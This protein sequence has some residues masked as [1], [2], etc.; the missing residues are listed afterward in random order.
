MQRRSGLFAVALLSAVVLGACSS[1]SATAP[2]TTASTASTASTTSTTAGT[3][4]TGGGPATSSSVAPP[5]SSTSTTSGSAVAGG[6][7][8]TRLAASVVGQQGAAGTQ[9]ATVVLRNTSTTPCG[10][11]GYPGL[12]LVSASGA[13]L[14]TVVVR[15]GTYSFTAMAPAATT[16]QPGKAVYFNMGYSD[17]P[18]GNETTCPTSAAME[19]TPPNAYGH[20][21]VTLHIAPCNGG[22]IA[23]SPVFVLTPA[24]TMT[25]APA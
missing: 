11:S 21:N 17:V 2:S 8:A 15:G 14:P 12:Q 9:E 22:T 19:I 25:T 5:A 7:T 16:L 24:T 23:V 18:T 4:G 13:V 6:C 20:L 1:R 10:L 3:G